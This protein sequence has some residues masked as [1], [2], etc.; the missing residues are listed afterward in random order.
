M[1]ACSASSLPAETVTCLSGCG[2]VRC[3]NVSSVS[4]PDAGRRGLPRPIVASVEGR[5]CMS[6]A[7]LS[8]ADINNTIRCRQVGRANCKVLECVCTVAQGFF[9]RRRIA[10]CPGYHRS[11]SAGPGK[12]WRH[13]GFSLSGGASSG[14]LNR[15]T[16][17]VAP[18]SAKRHRGC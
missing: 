5:L 1:S 12:R 6:V 10:P 4:S 17:L 14:L 3:L 11:R 7:L 13:R 18:V 9:R 8:E 15:R 16:S 2:E